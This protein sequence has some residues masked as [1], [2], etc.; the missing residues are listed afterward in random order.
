MSP[1]LA[2]TKEGPPAE[3]VHGEQ[4]DQVGRQVGHE[5]QAVAQV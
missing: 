1:C 4:A 5:H 2:S 3:P